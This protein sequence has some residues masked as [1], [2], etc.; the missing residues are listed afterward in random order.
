MSNAAALVTTGTAVA[1][2]QYAPSLP[3]ME[4]LRAKARYVAY[5]GARGGGK[6]WVI[7][8][9]AKL[10]AIRYPGIKILIV[11][12]TFRELDNNHIQPLLESLRGLARY[13][14]QDKCFRFHNR[15]TISFLYC[16]SDGDLEMYQGSEWDVIMIDESTNLREEWLAKIDAC[17]RGTGPYPRRT[18]YCCNP[19]GVSH[20]WHRRLFVDRRFGPDEHP[21]D[22][23]FI[24]AKVTDNH[25][26]MAAQPEYLRQLQNLPPKLRAAWL[27]GSWDIFEGAVFEEFRIEPTAD[28]R[29][30][31][32]IPAEGFKV[33]YGWEIYRSFDWGFRRPFSVGYWA[34]D[35]DGV[36]Y[37]IAE[38]YGCQR[39][40]RTHESIP[41]EGLKWSPDK[42]FAEIKE[43]EETHPLLAGRSITGVADPAIW[44]ASVGISIAESAA[45][46]GIY[47]V[48]GD[49]KRHAGWMQC[50]YRL[51]FDDEGYP[52]MY[53][54]DSCKDFIRTVPGLQ[55]DAHKVE[56]IDTEGEDHIADEWRYFCMSRPIKPIAAEPVYKPQ[57][58]PLD[59]FTTY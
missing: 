47:F 34:V 41:N 18:Y 31:H 54:L 30:T 6:S 43:Y 56:D 25:A 48:P 24:Q 53:V 11:R 14:R 44:D 9:K 17:C 42:V 16:A 29:W 22:Y 32:V 28:R 12:Q 5:G 38:Y 1:V 57:A 7:R 27:E 2:Q 37:R 40:L 35:Y 50:H 46:H 33:P 8:L 51:Q 13:N 49:H 52:R 59:M 15:S 19:G 58:D 4:F 21:D 45:D 23:V 39:D 36:I 10:L 20:A 55:Y 3:Q 26:L